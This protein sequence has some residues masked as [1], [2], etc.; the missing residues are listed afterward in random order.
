MA[1]VT[2]IITSNKTHRKSLPKMCN[3]VNEF[4]ALYD[5]DGFMIGD[6]DRHRDYHVKI[7]EPT[8]MQHAKIVVSIYQKIYKGTY[9]YL[10]MLDPL[11]EMG[12][13]PI[14]FFTNLLNHRTFTVYNGELRCGQ[15]RFVRVSLQTLLDRIWR[16]WHP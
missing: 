1:S 16:R 8:T 4:Y 10:E 3:S 11:D 5:E 13:F 2:K 7:I 6:Q 15:G 9:P 14:H 12:Y